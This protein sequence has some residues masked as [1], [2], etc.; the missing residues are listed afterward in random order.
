MRKLYLF[1]TLVLGALLAPIGRAAPRYAQVPLSRKPESSSGSAPIYNVTHEVTTLTM[2]DGIEISVTFTIPE[3]L[4]PGETFPVLFDYRP[5]RKDDS[6]YIHDYEF[7]PLLW[8]T[9]VRRCQ[10]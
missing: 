6:M 5:Y 4:Y 7:F 9:W 2:K 10:S 3:P 1:S 8:T